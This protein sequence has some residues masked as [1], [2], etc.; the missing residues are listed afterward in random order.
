MKSPQSVSLH[1]NPVALRRPKLH[2]VLAFLSAIGLRCD[3]LVFEEQNWKSRCC[4][5]EKCETKIVIH[6]N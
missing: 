1:F 3:F 4:N 2:T 6:F 5:R